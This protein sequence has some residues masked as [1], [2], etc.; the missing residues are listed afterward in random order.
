MEVQQYVPCMLLERFLEICPKQVR[1]KEFYIC[2]DDRPILDDKTANTTTDHTHIPL[3]SLATSIPCPAADRGATVVP[4]DASRRSSP[5]ISRFCPVLGW[6]TMLQLL[7]RRAAE[8]D[9]FS[10]PDRNALWSRA[11]DASLCK[12]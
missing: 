2:C 6:R 1:A 5:A 11:E 10:V 8:S 7:T 3:P 9:A 4:V 12:L